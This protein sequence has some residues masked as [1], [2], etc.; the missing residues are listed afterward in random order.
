MSKMPFQQ[1]AYMLII[2]GFGDK[3]NDFMWKNIIFW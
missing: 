2:G 3:E 1:D